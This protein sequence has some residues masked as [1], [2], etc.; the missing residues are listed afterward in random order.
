[1]PERRV[2]VDTGPLI[3][4]VSERDRHHQVCVDTLAA[5]TPPLWT[6]WP[7]LTE[8]AWLLRQSP[9]ALD[10]LFGA[11]DEH[12]F[13]LRPLEDEAIGWVAQFLRRYASIRAQLADAAL[14]YLA[15]RK[16]VR[17]V[18][19]FDRR[20]FSVYPSDSIHG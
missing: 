16:N 9:A 14:V 19:T 18:F 20:D 4:L 2:L 5:L 15:E 7:V 13:A 8:T 11:F 3:A 12:L 1:V 6:C 10:K 17:T